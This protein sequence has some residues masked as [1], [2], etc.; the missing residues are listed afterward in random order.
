MTV[1]AAGVTL[2]SRQMLAHTNIN[3]KQISADVIME[4]K[5][6]IANLITIRQYL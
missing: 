6:K 2:Y 3:S 5:I 4:T 1:N